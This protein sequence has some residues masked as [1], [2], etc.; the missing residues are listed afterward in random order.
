MTSAERWD[1]TEPLDRRQLRR[2]RRVIDRAMR[3]AFSDPVSMAQM[4]RDWWTQVT[5]AQQELI[6]ERNPGAFDLLEIAKRSLG[7]E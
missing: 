1:A 7:S 6:A 5:N 4:E 3:K 2:C